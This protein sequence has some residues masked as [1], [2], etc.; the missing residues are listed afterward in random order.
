[1]ENAEA[2]YRWLTERESQSLSFCTTGRVSADQNLYRSRSSRDTSYWEEEGTVDWSHRG[3]S[4]F[5]RK[6]AV[7]ALARDLALVLVS[8]SASSTSLIT[9]LDLVLASTRE[10]SSCLGDVPV[11][12]F[13]S[14]EVFCL[15]KNA[16]QKHPLR[17]ITGK[18]EYQNCRS[19]KA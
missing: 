12:Y 9:D 11:A 15:S 10:I 8:A 18:E 1:L 19:Q 14:T 5:L 6:Q 2:F 7:T 3:P 13:P 4:G 16:Q 17:L